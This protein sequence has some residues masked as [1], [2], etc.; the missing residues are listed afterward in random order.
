MQVCAIVNMAQV[1]VMLL[2]SHVVLALNFT[3]VV[4]IC[5]IIKVLL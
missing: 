4:N 2:G 5:A 1:K 3:M